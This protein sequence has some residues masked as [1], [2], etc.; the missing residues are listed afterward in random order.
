MRKLK[1]KRVFCALLIITIL[2]GWILLLRNYIAQSL[3]ELTVG[4]LTGLRVDI[5]STKVYFLKPA[6]EI[7]NLI[8]YNP[9]GFFDSIMMHLPNLYL[10]PVL[11]DLFKG[12]IRFRTLRLELREFD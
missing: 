4:S 3:I 5:Q 11:M 2:I 10:E 6:V 9:P 1:G 12:R 7:E 8:L